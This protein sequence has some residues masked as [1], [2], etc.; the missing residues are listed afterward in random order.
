MEVNQTKTEKAPGMR[1]VNDL[2][3]KSLKGKHP[4][5]SLSSIICHATGK[6]QQL[7]K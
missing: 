3:Y 5:I 4:H 1:E 6:I 7:K 2:N